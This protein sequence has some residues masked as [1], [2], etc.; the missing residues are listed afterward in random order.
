MQLSFSKASLVTYWVSIFIS[1]G[2]IELSGNC[3]EQSYSYLSLCCR[4]GWRECPR[5]LKVSQ[6]IKLLGITALKDFC[7]YKL[8]YLCQPPTRQNCS[9]LYQIW[10]FACISNTYV[11]AIKFVTWLFAK[12]LKAW[13]QINGQING[14][15]KGRN[16]SSLNPKF[17]F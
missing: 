1:S 15:K 2:L 4:G 17:D 3:P 14:S 13:G 5:L 9:K 6:F 8:Y 10:I 12:G 11:I 16:Y 7:L